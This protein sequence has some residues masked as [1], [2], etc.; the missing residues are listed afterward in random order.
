MMLSYPD[1][2]CSCPPNVTCARTI[3]MALSLKALIL[4]YRT[5]RVITSFSELPFDTH[6]GLSL[7]LLNRLSFAASAR[8]QAAV[9]IWK[10][11]LWQW[12]FFLADTTGSAQLSKS[13]LRLLSLAVPLCIL[14][15]LGKL[16]DVL[17]APNATLNDIINDFRHVIHTP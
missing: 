7:K 12:V 9:W 13:R 8:A 15:K 10:H 11:C 3:T 14:Q 1:H 4:V 16:L 6:P 2:A 5:L 17:F